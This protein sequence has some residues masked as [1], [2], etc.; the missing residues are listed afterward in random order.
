MIKR[1]ENCRGC[2][3]ENMTRHC[4]PKSKFMSCPCISCL[5]KSICFDSCENFEKYITTLTKEG[6]IE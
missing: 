3:V 6:E 5:V 2:S 1:D 4:R